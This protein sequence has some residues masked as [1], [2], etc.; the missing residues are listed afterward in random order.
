MENIIQITVEDFSL[1]LNALIVGEVLAVITGLLIYE[2]LCLA[3]RWLFRSNDQ[4][5]AQTS[6]AGIS[7]HDHVKGAVS[8]DER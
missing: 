3:V 7:E 8:P 4:Q 1:L 6:P 2:G 5:R